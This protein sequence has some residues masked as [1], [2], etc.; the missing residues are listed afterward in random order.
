M[1]RPLVA[2]AN[3]EVVLLVIIDEDRILV[4]NGRQNGR[5]IRVLVSP[6]LVPSRLL[7]PP[8]SVQ[9]PKKHLILGPIR[10]VG[11][12]APNPFARRGVRDIPLTALAVRSLLPFLSP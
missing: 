8:K 9:K 10:T 5:S 11:K 12:E 2:S 4:I 3:N 1:S 6:A 7:L